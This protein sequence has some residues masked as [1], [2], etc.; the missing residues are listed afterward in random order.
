M[1]HSTKVFIPLL[2]SMTISSAVQA[3]SLSGY[4]LSYLGSDTLDT[5]TKFIYLACGIGA[6]INVVSVARRILS[7]EEAQQ[8]TINWAVSLLLACLLFVTINILRG[9]SIGTGITGVTG[10]VPTLLQKLTEIWPF[11]WPVVLAAIGLGGALILPGKIRLVQQGEL[12]GRGQIV[13][14]VT[15]LTLGLCFIYIVNVVFF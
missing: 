4:Y 3:E 2:L 1:Y 8:R 11:V 14:W 9:T 12:E 5:V 13:G 15:G 10:L 7:G 6:G